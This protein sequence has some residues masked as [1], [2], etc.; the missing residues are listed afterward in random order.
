MLKNK[1]TNSIMAATS[2][3]SMG[4][5][6]IG[7]TATTFAAPADATDKASDTSEVTAN[8]QTGG[9]NVVVAGNGETDNNTFL[10]DLKVSTPIADS[11]TAN[12]LTITDHTGAEGWNLTV[13]AD[14][15]AE[16]EATLKVGLKVDDFARVNL[17]DAEATVAS[18]ISQL[19]DFVLDGTF[20]AQWGTTPEKGDYVSDLTWSLTPATAAAGGGE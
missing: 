5:G 1:V 6:L 19:D 11:T 12:L 13:K 3:L 15:Y 7:T 4:V 20:D 8:I 2:I 9:M 18:G 17:T 14:N 10:G 16:T